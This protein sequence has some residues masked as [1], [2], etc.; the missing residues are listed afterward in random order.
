MVDLPALERDMTA[1]RR[2]LHA[3]P[4]FGFEEKRTTRLCR[5]QAARVRPRR[6]RRGRRRHGRRRHAET[7]QRQPRHR[8]PGRHGCP[9]HHR[10]GHTRATARRIPARCMPAGM[11]ATRPCCSGPRSCSPRRRL[12]RHRALR[13][14]AG[15]GMGQ[16]ARSPCWPTGCM[17]RFPFEEIYGLHNM[18]G[19]RR[20][21][22][23]DP[24]RARSCRRRT[25]SRSSLR[26]VG[27]HAARPHP[28]TRCWSPPARLVIISR[29]SSRVA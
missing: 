23:P 11:T 8:A 29:P 9:A 7:R 20:R 18:P 28:A 13:L 22:L 12:R 10:A 21:A 16:A 1:W 27:G 15:R 14:P 5:R 3:H 26:G 19:L 17:E 25:I 6:G 2:D 4:E 24:R